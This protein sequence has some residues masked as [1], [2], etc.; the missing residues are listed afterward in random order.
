MALTLSRQV[1]ESII[2]DETIVVTVVKLRGGR[3]A[4]SIEAPKD[5]PVRRAEL[6]K[7]AA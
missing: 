6:E 3:V 7:K 5:V 1:G 4:I 2:I